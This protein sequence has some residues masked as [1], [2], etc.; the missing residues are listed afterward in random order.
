MEYTQL[1]AFCTYLHLKPT[2]ACA[3]LLACRG[4]ITLHPIVL[5]EEGRPM[6]TAIMHLRRFAPAV[7]HGEILRVRTVH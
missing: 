2:W 6:S 4:L 3:Q 7:A 5:T 1:L